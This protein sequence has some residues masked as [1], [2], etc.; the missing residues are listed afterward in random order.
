MGVKKKYT[1][2]ETGWDVVFVRKKKSTAVGFAVSC[3][4]PPVGVQ[5]E[6]KVVGKGKG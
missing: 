3:G 5:I 1:G 2:G 4:A 6:E